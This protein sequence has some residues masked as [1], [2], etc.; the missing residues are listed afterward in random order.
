ML[1]SKYGIVIPKPIGEQQSA[2]QGCCL[3]EVSH[4]VREARHSSIKQLQTIVC[5]LLCVAL[6]VTRE[7]RDG[8]K[9]YME[10]RVIRERCVEGR[11]RL[12]TRMSGVYACEARLAQPPLSPTNMHGVPAMTLSPSHISNHTLVSP[13]GDCALNSTDSPSSFSLGP[14]LQRPDKGNSGLSGHIPA[15]AN[16][17]GWASILEGEAGKNPQG[18]LKGMARHPAALGGNSAGTQD[19]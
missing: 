1:A 4:L 10:A 7:L 19:T 3:P 9:G 17:I 13:T 6:T 8:S 18:S 15:R 14:F 5:R 16:A 12:R 11:D 2:K